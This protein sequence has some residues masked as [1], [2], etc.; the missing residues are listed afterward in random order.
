MPER[1]NI[2]GF[3]CAGQRSFENLNEGDIIQVTDPEHILFTCLLTVQSVE[4]LR[5]LAYATLPDL[6]NSPKGL[7][8][9]YLFDP[10]QIIT[11]G[12]ALLWVVEDKLA[13]EVKSDQAPAAKP[14]G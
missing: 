3:D 6:P 2:T 4:P 1:L 9:I 13:A 14:D 10:G 12:H 7:L 5:V 11:V 8:Y